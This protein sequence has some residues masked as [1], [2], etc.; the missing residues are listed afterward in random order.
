MIKKLFIAYWIGYLLINLLIIEVSPLPWYDETYMASIAKTLADS[1]HLYAQI[2]WA[3][4]IE[5]P[6]VYGP[7]FFWITY[8]VLKLFGFGIWQYRI[9]IILSGIGCLLLSHQLIKTHYP[10][11]RTVYLLP[12]LLSI[13]PFF[14]RSMHEGRMD[15]WA[16]FFLLYATLYLLKVFKQPQNWSAVIFS[17]LLVGL[18]LNTSPRSAFFAV[19]LGLFG[20]P[21]LFK[22]W[23]AYWKKAIIWISI[24]S[25]LY[26]AWVQYAY[27]GF[28]NMFAFFTQEGYWGFTRINPAK[29]SILAQQYPLMLSALAVSIYGFFRLGKA[30]FD[31]LYLL[32][33]LSIGCFYLLVFDQ[34]PYVAY[35]IPSYY[36][37]IFSVV[38]RITSQK[39]VSSQYV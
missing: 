8:P 34:G 26:I 13:D 1:G 2:A 31:D 32:A 27:G 17:G 30:I 36:L 18:A 5:Y 24:P 7:V 28:S 22:N 19:A 12:I 38:I 25:L 3:H 35:I 4:Q 11:K 16:T 14:F 9:T 21:K 23:K 15:L 29:T 33:L 20:L 37:L 6:P 39:S 10:E